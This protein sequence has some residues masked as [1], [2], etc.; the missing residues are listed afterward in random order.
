MAPARYVAM[1]RKKSV[2]VPMSYDTVDLIQGPAVVDI[3]GAAGLEMEAAVSRSGLFLAPA[4]SRTLPPPDADNSQKRDWPQQH[5]DPMQG[6]ISCARRHAR[7]LN[8]NQAALKISMGY[9]GLKAET[10]PWREQPTG[11]V[12]TNPKGSLTKLLIAKGSPE[13]EHI[14]NMEQIG[15]GISNR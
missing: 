11:V 6:P 2:P 12:G 9:R 14:A 15:Y 1:Q 10:H 5:P 4:R 8:S 13:K 7:Q 3:E